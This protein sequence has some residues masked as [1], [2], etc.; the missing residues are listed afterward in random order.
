MD[1][2]S[3]FVS[4]SVTSAYN[5][6]WVFLVEW[7]IVFFAS[8]ILIFYFNRIIG[9]IVTYFFT[10]VLWRRTRTKL[11]IQAIK[12]NLL[13]GRIFLKNATIVTKNEIVLVHSAVLTWKYWIRFVRKSQ[14]YVQK[15]NLNSTINKGLPS[16][17]TLDI[18]GLEVFV[19]NRS[20]AYHDLENILKSEAKGFKSSHRYSSTHHRKSKASSKSSGKGFARE[21]TESDTLK[22]RKNQTTSTSYSIS[23]DISYDKAEEDRE[24]SDYDTSINALDT[25]KPIEV[26]DSTFLNFLPFEINVTKGSFVLG[27][28]TTPSLYVASF[29]A[30]NGQIDATLP[31]SPLDYYRTHYDFTV[32][33]L[34][35]E[36]KTNVGFEDM[37]SLEKKIREVNNKKKTKRFISIISGLAQSIKTLNSSYNR[38]PRKYSYNEDCF[39][40]STENKSESDIEEWHGLERYLTTVSSSN[41]D[42]YSRLYDYDKQRMI[43][44][45]Y[46]KDSTIL[47]SQTC[48]IN[49]YY[50][51]QGL[52]PFEKISFDF[53]EMP[54][55][56]NKDSPPMFGLDI[57]V[58][59]T[60]ISYGP[61]AEKQRGPLHQLLFPPLY[62]NAVAFK[63]LKPGMRRQYVSFDMSIQCDDELSFRIPHREESK[64][65]LFFKNKIPTLRHFGWVNLK[66]GK[67]SITDFSISLIPTAER[68]I[69]NKVNAVF[70]RPEISTSVNH[71][72]LFEADEHIF[73]ASLALPLEWNALANWKF[74]NISKNAN[75]YLLKEHVN[76]LSDLFSDFA[77]GEPTPY[78]LFRPF[79]YRLNWNLYD[80]AIYLNINEENI[81]NNPLDNTVNTYLTFKGVFLNLQTKIPLISVYKKSNTVDYVL[82]TSAFDLSIE[83]PSSSTFSNFLQTEEIGNA[84]NFKVE[85]SYTYFSFMEIDAVDTIVMDCTCDDTTVKVYGFA[86][87]YFMALKE[88]Y[89][90]DST[91]FQNLLEFRETFGKNEID[92][93]LEGKRLKNETD[94][95]FSF[96]VK[97]GC[98]AFPCHLYDCTSH[99]A[100]HFDTLDI[101]IRNNNYYMDLQGNFSEVRGR[102]IDNC[103][104]STIFENT[105]SKVD[106][107]P[108]LFIDELSIHSI[109]I[110]G[111]PPKNP[112][113]FCR[114]SFDTNGIKIEAEPI[115]LNALSRAKMSFTFGHA[116]LE[117]SLGLAVTPVM[118]ILNLSFKCPTISIKLKKSNYCF[119]LTLSALNLKL[120]DQPTPLYNSLLHL[121]IESIILECYQNDLQI[122]KLITSLELKNFDQK[123]KAF[124]RMQAQAMHIKK[125]DAPYHR[126]PFL[127]PEFAKDRKYFKGFNSLKSSLN[128]PDPPLPLTNQSLEEI[129]DNFPLHIQQ[130]LLNM[131]LPFED[132]DN[133]SEYMHDCSSNLEDFVVLKQLNSNCAYDNILV[134]L[135]KFETFISPLISLVA[136]DFISSMTHFNIYTLL[137]KLQTDFIDFFKF[138][139]GNSIMKCKIEC[140]LVTLKISYTFDSTD[141]V[142]VGISDLV[143][144]CAKS[145]VN[146][147]TGMNSYTIIKELNC[148]FVKDTEDAFL[149][150][151]QNVLF[152]QSFET[153]QISTIDLE[154]IYLFV[155]PVY[156][157]WII[158]WVFQFKTNVESAI[159]RWNEFQKDVHSAGVE[160][161]YDL[162]R[163]GIDFNISHDP[164]CITKPSYITGFS[165]NHI[166]MDGNWMIIPRLR[167]VLQNLPNEWIVTKNKMF[168]EKIW[169]APKTAEDDVALIFGNWRCWDNHKTKDNFIF[170]KIFDIQEETK[171]KLFNSLKFTLKAF[172]FTINPF[173]NAFIISNI[174]FFWNEDTLSK[175]VR[176]IAM[177]LLDQPIQRCLDI[178]FKVDSIVLNFTKIKNIFKDVHSIICGV[179]ET[180]KKYS[181]DS[182]ISTDDDLGST[183][184]LNEVQRY[185][186]ADAI[187]ITLNCSLNEY[188]FSFGIDKTLLTFYGQN[189]IVTSSIIKAETVLSCT[190]NFENEFFSTEF[191][192]ER[193]AIFEINCEHH[194][195]ALVNTGSFKTG[196][197]ITS[198][199]TRSMIFNILPNSKSL[200]KAITILY[201]N[202][203]ACLKPVIDQFSEKSHIDSESV[204]VHFKTS[205][206]ELVTQKLN[207]NIFE[208]F[209]FDL[210]ASFSI[211]KL[212]VHLEPISP[213]FSNFEVGDSNLSFK[214]GE[215]GIV[216]EFL[217][218]NTKWSLS[219]QNKKYIFEYFTSTIEEMKFMLAVNYDDGV[220]RILVKAI[221]G[222][223]RLNLLKNNL[224]TVV[225][226]GLKDG[227]VALKNLEKLK[228]QIEKISFSAATNKVNQTTTPSA[229]MEKDNVFEKLG[230]LVHVIFHIN[231]ANITSSV[232]LNGN[233]LHFDC[234][235][236]EIIV[237]SFDQSLKKFAPYGSI[238]FP[239]IR[240]TIGLNGIHGVSTLFD[241]QSSIT[242]INSKAS[243]HKLRRMDFEIAY[244]RFVVNSHI[245]EEFIEAYG[246]MIL[247]LKRKK[248][249]TFASVET[250]NNSLPLDSLIAFFSINITAKDVCFGWLFN[251][252]DT[253]HTN[254]P[255]GIILG[256]ADATIS[257]AKDAGK[258]QTRGMYL[259]AAH[260]FTPATFYPTKSEKFSSNRAYFPL[261]D[262]IYIVESNG[263]ATNWR[264]QVDG[265]RIDFKFQTNIFLVTEPLRVSLNLLQEKFVNVKNKLRKKRGKEYYQDFDE[266]EDSSLSLLSPI[267][268]KN[269]TITT[270]RCLFKFAGASFFIYDS[271]I[272]IN[273]TIPILNL[274]S[275]GLSAVLRYTHDILAVKKHALLLSAL[276][277]ETNNKLS[278]L[279]VPVLQDIMKGVRHIMKNSNNKNMTK[280]I[281]TEE[282]NSSIDFVRLSEK[283]DVNF[284]LKIQPQFLSLTCEPRANIEA[285]VALQEIHLVVKTDQDFLSGV[286]TVK[287][288]K[289][290]LKHAYSKVTSGSI[291]I[292]NLTING[293]MSVVNYENKVCCVVKLDDVDTFINIQQRQDLDLFR[294]F[295]WPSHYNK[296]TLVSKAGTADRK[297]FSSMVRDVS[298][299]YAFPW[300]ISLIFSKVS[301]KIN[302]GSSLGELNVYIENLMAL[303]AKNINWDHNLKVGFDLMNIESKG[304]LSGILRV[305]KSKMT[306]A[307]SWKKNG[308][309]LSI[310]LVLL[311]FGISGLQTKILLDYHPFFILEIV[312]CGV[313]IYN[314]R[315]KNAHDKL[316]SSLNVESFKVFMTALT[317]SNFVDVYTIGLRIRQDIKLSYR[318]VLN[319]A[320]V[321]V[322]EKVGDDLDQQNKDFKMSNTAETEGNDV[323]LSK[324]FLIMIEKLQTYLNVSIGSL[325][326]QIFPSS[327]LDSQAMVINVGRQRAMFYQNNVD[328]MKNKIA[329]DLAD[330]TV[331]LSSFRKRPTVEALNDPMG[332]KSYVDMASNSIDDNI[333]VFPSLK[334]SMDTVQNP[335]NNIIKYKYFCKFDGKVDIKWK[336]GS[337]YF[338]RQ[339]WY[340]HA[341]SLS[342]RLTALRFYT[343]DEYS[344]DFEEN[345]KE[346]TLESVNLE[347]RLKDAE[348]D[349]KYIYQ[350]TEEPVI[351]TPQLKDLGSATPPLE[352]FGLHRNKFP[353]LTHQ[354]VIVA[355]Q[356]VIQEVEEKYAKVLK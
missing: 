153:R 128:L 5:L 104:E 191:Y 284:T 269:S 112:T 251:Q 351:E 350:S 71:D 89:F 309:V 339:M 185:E 25:E 272:E 58:S 276:I 42:L 202:D 113:Y 342:N 52:V 274:Q 200:A 275:P 221:S 306:S 197:T 137:D 333:F 182:S 32:S 44:T 4:R 174:F 160:L 8:L 132:H 198:I 314:Q 129:I 39:T 224:V 149:A 311:S 82:E 162:S 45:E 163:G 26:M 91:H 196:K 334:I 76:L 352:W 326:I 50:D 266:P 285:E 292:N 16:R 80:Y 33:D 294:D 255:P 222:I 68:G 93:L 211:L 227:K 81:I 300:M 223:I 246:D 282:S 56:G 336:I 158:D 310:P 332:I 146:T 105:K 151:F 123:K 315:Q 66:L 130:K 216:S 165:R 199:S 169:E 305:Q 229:T 126:I 125:H 172:T 121:I 321:S 47:E 296:T 260:G 99:L 319:D 59:G 65:I 316:K 230:H 155:E 148:D 3:K 219:S 180:L 234:F 15:Q 143:F 250:K 75:I 341:T 147:S 116:D 329:L 57:T 9:S 184:S 10:Y 217:V 83:H 226:M 208:K 84:N 28:E 193:I 64:D 74:E 177:P 127:I 115:F 168:E 280:A 355:L 27:N 238:K 43:D 36:L 92:P 239:S 108:E 233:K 19:Y 141:Y 307:T 220:Y 312:N 131:S 95:M 256:F 86:I 264:A 73:S 7:L 225:D 38:R 261:F 181:S 77:S 322:N 61:W 69:D 85:G 190:L 271:D 262:L 134:N 20:S 67:G 206:L 98:L 192:V 195:T 258:L 124:E 30:M 170:K 31:G 279:C 204:S 35:L 215:F 167:H 231:F 248:T 317:A 320:Q 242:V 49:Y 152:K 70:V 166:R 283:I 356:K 327:L 156:V 281:K 145:N 117:N 313:T 109:R 209:Q 161:L 235:K 210:S 14:F 346:S 303:S 13:S 308:E 24:F 11:S 243:D 201:E 46:A 138:K 23:P 253:R 189:S 295:W 328:D 140:P 179:Q 55:I 348:S 347:D 244:C 119:T 171:T 17:F 265:E 254:S 136:V 188:S 337:V 72:V 176:A 288:I 289:S 286:L 301:A 207:T 268:P 304:R 122:L 187:L 106:F 142:F 232:N 354:F 63:K 194:T 270:I 353:N 90:G 249:N 278:C 293:T 299:T 212:S 41:S 79:I 34:L 324:T 12:I 96:C 87:K 291:H 111:L 150:T 344:D 110:F 54:D 118:D 101:D 290:E 330:I 345:Y 173:T 48:K 94:L 6:N 62:R 159:N 100:L 22:R 164:Q 214:L 241:M 343:S 21:S 257:C 213:F 29:T 335:D 287:S 53:I 331:S 37:D 133:D 340:S 349:K 135:G 107:E 267:S 183:A 245:V 103:D 88:N 51:S 157:P 78:E 120:S 40:N 154:D 203:Y 1:V 186:A 228:N 2:T 252:D 236:P 338:I 18:V 205:Q 325:E 114:W 175:D 178:T 102:Y 247:V 259:A 273:G 263:R 318:Q 97:N 302:L 298:T 237:Q 144:A 218:R 323:R 277:S 60:T 240:L 297:T 139:Q